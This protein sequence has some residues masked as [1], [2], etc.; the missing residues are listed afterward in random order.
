MGAIAPVTLL[1]AHGALLRADLAGEDVLEHHPASI[2][3]GCPAR[4]N[5]ARAACIGE[6]RAWIRSQNRMRPVRMSLNI[7]QSPMNEYSGCLKVAGRFFSK[8]KCPTHANP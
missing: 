1:R 6:P 8:K 4:T 5:A 3:T 7:T 2:T